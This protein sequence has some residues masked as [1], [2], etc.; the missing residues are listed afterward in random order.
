M[1]NSLSQIDHR[2]WPLP[3]EK[4]Q[5]SQHWKNA[6]FIHF[7]VETEV[8]RKFVPDALEIDTIDGKAY[9][10]VVA[11][12]MNKVRPRNLPYFPPVSNFD[13][14]NIR[15]YV[16]R[17]GKPGVYFISVEVGS[18]IAAYIAR[19]LS[20]FPYQFSAMRVKKDNAAANNVGYQSQFNIDFTVGDKLTNKSPLD[21][22]LTERYAAYNYRNG[23]INYYDIHH[24][25]WPIYKVRTDK[26]TLHYPPFDILFEDGPKAVHFSQGVHT[27]TFP[28]K[29]F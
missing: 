19:K 27:F 5:Y 6:V 8:L 12:K 13:E 26:L 16:T 14:V 21:F 17:K 25:E 3:E 4:W 24:E 7:E 11:F 29:Q 22:W 1:A 15:T 23:V 10:S 18:G 28:L 2:P 20:G 9:V